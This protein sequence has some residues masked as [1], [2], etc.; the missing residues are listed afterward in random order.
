MFRIG[1]ESIFLSSFCSDLWRDSAACAGKGPVQD[2]AARAV[3]A[4]AYRVRRGQGLSQHGEAAEG[5]GI[6]KAGV[7]GQNYMENIIHLLFQWK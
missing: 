5:E 4:R 3:R 2:R 7:I 1:Y 6:H